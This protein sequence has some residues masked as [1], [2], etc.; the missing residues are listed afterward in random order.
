MIEQ[1]QALLGFEQIAASEDDQQQDHGDYSWQDEYEQEPEQQPGAA[2]EAKQGR[3]NWMNSTLLTVL[4][5]WSCRKHHLVGKT[6]QP[7]RQGQ[8]NT[9][10]E[11]LDSV[12]R[13]QPLLIDHMTE[14]TL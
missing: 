10:K 6:A 5:Q 9:W 14:I 13:I 4:R 12:I 11:I 2:A 7:T 1:Y 3:F 8:A